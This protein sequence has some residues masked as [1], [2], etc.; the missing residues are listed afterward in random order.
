MGADAKN[1]ALAT[2][3]IVIRRIASSY[4]HFGMKTPLPVVWVSKS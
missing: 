1:L 4:A 3:N 2:T